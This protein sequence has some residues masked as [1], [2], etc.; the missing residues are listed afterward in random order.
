MKIADALALMVTATGDLQ[1]LARGLP[2]NPAELAA[3]AKT[4]KPDTA[5]AVALAI[6][7]KQQPAQQVPED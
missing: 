1:L 5:E 2:V 6:L 3:A 4:A 7:A